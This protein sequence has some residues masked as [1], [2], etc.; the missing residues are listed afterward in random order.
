MCF[1][2]ARKTEFT[3]FRLKKN[4]IQRNGELAVNLL[5]CLNL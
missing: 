1:G 2:A 3:M 4:A 5:K